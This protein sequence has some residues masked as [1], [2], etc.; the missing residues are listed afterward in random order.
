MNL[1]LSKKSIKKLTADKNS[2][3]LEATPQVGGAAHVSVVICNTDDICWTQR[4][5]GQACQIYTHH[6]N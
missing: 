4:G 3:P 5:D 6:C 1:K 2:L